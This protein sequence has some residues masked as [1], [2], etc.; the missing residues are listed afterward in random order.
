ME[1]MVRGKEDT[2]TCPVLF[3]GENKLMAVSMPLTE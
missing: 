3:T 2:G 1:Q